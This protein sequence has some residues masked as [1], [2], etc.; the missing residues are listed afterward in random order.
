MQQTSSLQVFGQTWHFTRDALTC[1]APYGVRSTQMLKA[2]IIN[3]ASSK[4]LAEGEYEMHFGGAELR[5]TVRGASVIV[6]DRYAPVV[7]SR[8]STDHRPH[9]LH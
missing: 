7:R 6:D 3:L 2:V 1:L 4:G 9:P 8:R 5:V